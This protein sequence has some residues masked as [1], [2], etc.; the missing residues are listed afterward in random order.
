M[1]QNVQR[2]LWIGVSIL[3]F[4][5]VVAIG[6]NVFNQS[7]SMVNESSEGLARTSQDLMNTRYTSLEGS[8]ISGTSVVSAIREHR[9]EEG[10]IILQV[11]TGSGNTYQYISSG[12]ISGDSVTG[13]LSARTDTSGDITNA[14]DSSHSQYI[15]PTGQFLVSLSYDANDVIRAVSYTQQ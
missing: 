4:V 15:N 2:A 5:A 7:Q 9:G 14:K 11:V 3:L 13:S 1:D 10:D 12:T 8:V 6:M